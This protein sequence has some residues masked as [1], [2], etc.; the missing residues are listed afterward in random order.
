MIVTIEARAGERISLDLTRSLGERVEIECFQF[1]VP[2]IE[3]RL[4]RNSQP[5]QAWQTGN[6][7]LYDLQHAPPG[8]NWCR[9]GHAFI[10]DLQ[11]RDGVATCGVLS[12]DLTLETTGLGFHIILLVWPRGTTFRAKPGAVESLRIIQPEAAL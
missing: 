10:N 8:K 9:D 4:A 5:L 2:P 6:T 3:F 1:A 7:K 11:H 12:K